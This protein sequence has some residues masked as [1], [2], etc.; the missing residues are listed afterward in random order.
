VLWATEQAGEG[1]LELRYP[2][3]ERPEPTR[4]DE[5]ATYTDG[6]DIAEPVSYE[7]N[8]GLGEIVQAVLDAGLTLTRL[9]E[10]DEI[11]WPAYPWFEPSGI[12]DHWRMPGDR[13]VVP[14]EYT[15]EACRP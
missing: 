1:R 14:L 5:P 9:V 10:H 12:R 2:Y 8:H 4:F 6:P 3:F 15:L 7:W 11:D 13:S